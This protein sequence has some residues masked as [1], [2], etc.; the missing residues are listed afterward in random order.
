MNKNTLIL[1]CFVAVLASV[2]TAVMLDKLQI[3]S[4]L[5]AAVNSV[6][7]SRH[8]A[9]VGTTLSDAEYVKGLTPEEKLNI[10]VYEQTSRS[11]VNINTQSRQEFFFREAIAQGEGSGS[12][13]DH[14]GHILTNFHVISGANAVQVVLFN[15]NAYTA[16]LV[17]ADPANDCAVL[18]IKAPK[19]E[20]YPVTF[21]NSERLRVG[22]KVYAIGNPFGLELTL[23]TGIVSSLNRS[24]PSQ[25]KIRTIKQV[26]QIDAAINPGNSGGPLLDSHGEVIGMNVAIASRSGDSAGVGFAIPVNTLARVIPQLIRHGKVLRP[27]LGVE[28]VMPT[29]EGLLITKVQPGGPAAKAGLSSPKMANQ[30]R[31]QGNYIYEYQTMDKATAEIITAVNG[32]TVKTADDLLTLIESLSPGETVHVSV[33][34]DGKTRKVAVILGESE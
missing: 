12:V 16:T 20:L 7:E 24:L 34:R 22:Q 33:L 2:T 26:I 19:D 27:N 32:E 18:K 28:Q 13:L 9:L 29:E 23:S 25:S 4:F 6:Q 14:E 17:G 15:G 1:S 21:G 11:V 3:S 10:R 5:N 30:K 8:V 31:R